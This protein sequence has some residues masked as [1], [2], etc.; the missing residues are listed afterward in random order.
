MAGGILGVG[1]TGLQAAQLGLTTTSHNIANASTPGFNRQVAIQDAQIPQLTG[2]GFVGQGTQV[3][4]IQRQFNQFLN[5]QVVLGES[6]S[7]A[8]D[9]FNA[10]ITQINDLLADP[11][12]GLGPALQDF[13]NSVHDVANEPGTVV[14][15]Q[16]LLGAAQGLVGRFGMLDQRL[17]ELRNGVNQQITSTVA[18]LNSFGTE[19][20]QLN[21]RIALAE[22]TAQQPAND[23]RDQR[24][25][26]VLEL[27]RLVGASVVEQGN[28]YSVFIGNGVPI[29]IGPQAFAL[30][31]L[32]SPTDPGRT[33]VGVVTPGGTVQIQES[34]LQGGSLGGL[35]A[36][37][38]QSLD[39]AQNA[40]GRI[41]VVLAGTFND[42]HVLG[43]DLNGALGGNFFNVPSAQVTAGSGNTGNAQLAAAYSNYGAL[44]T[45]DYQI[46]YD[47]VN[48]VVTR[49]ADNTQQSFAALPA[50]IDGVTVTLAAGAPNAGDQFLLRPTAGG[51]S[52]ISVAITDPTKVAAAAPIRTSQGAA[53]TGSATISAG[54]VNTPP[55]PNVNLTQTVTITFNNPPTTFK[56]VGVGTG[57]P[58]AVA[59]ASGGNV[60]F[61]GWT[62]QIAGAPAA[63]DT[64]T[65]SANGGGI[66]DNRNALLLAALQS[67]NTIG[68]GTAT[69]QSAYGQLVSQVG[70]DTQQAQTRAD[71]QKTFL[72]QAKGAR[73]SLSGVNLD[74]E[75]AN[76]IRYQQ[77]YQASARAIQIGSKLFDDLLAIVQ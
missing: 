71:A 72:D 54:A 11:S 60:S 3:D 74:E 45:S 35:L 38:S 25:Q 29:V 28:S 53:N 66:S 16:A 50:T 65:V 42:Q 46:A 69:Y 30:G 26:L 44:T 7:A 31:T 24:D 9:A 2:S 12:A 27:N 32:A 55:P 48:Y 57:N 40:L 59:Y 70:S 22:S 49:L 17:G 68:G 13:F 6:Q 23:L 33:V 1:I 4:T 41:A 51:A 63:G 14:T 18:Q 37:R 5:R 77:A 21:G 73:E 39:P 75:A 47:G 15:R 20:A 67:Q 34:V 76:L 43:Q 64:F 52:G 61:N 62:A 56:V 36:F 58:P 8:L 10:Q 19:I